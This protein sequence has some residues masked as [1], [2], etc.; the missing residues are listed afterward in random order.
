[1]HT[2][3]LARFAR[4][5]QQRGIPYCDK[6]HLEHWISV[7]ETRPDVFARP[8]G[9]PP[10]LAEVAAPLAQ[11]SS[12][13][14]QVGAVASGATAKALSRL[15]RHA[16][17]ELRPYK[18]LGVAMIVVLDGGGPEGAPLEA[19]DLLPLAEALEDRRPYVS[20]VLVSLAKQAHTQVASAEPEWPMRV[21]ILHNPSAIVPLHL[22]I[23]VEPEDEHMVRVGDRWVDIRTGALLL[24]REGPPA[25]PPTG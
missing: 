3:G 16:A 2:G 7:Q 5:L 14:A 11:E 15:V 12:G 13:P 21:R 10:F 8:L 1:M 19:Q 23:F 20:A 22:G 6:E 25:S 24:P 18:R 17:G 4:L 9:F